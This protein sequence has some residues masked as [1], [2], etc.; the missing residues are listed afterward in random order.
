LHH[1]TGLNCEISQ[2]DAIEIMKKKA[3]DKIIMRDALRSQMVKREKYV[4]Q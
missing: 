3:A 4:K 1:P 2:K